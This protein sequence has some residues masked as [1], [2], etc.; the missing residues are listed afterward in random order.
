MPRTDPDMLAEREALSVLP[1]PASARNPHPDAAEAEAL[2]PIKRMQ[3]A[4][5]LMQTK[6]A[7]I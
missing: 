2:R 5:A 4:S 6:I 3:S 1:A 7:P